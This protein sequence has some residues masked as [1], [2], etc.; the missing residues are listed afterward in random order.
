M[1]QHH[2]FLGYG[3]HHVHR[4]LHHLPVSCQPA[5]HRAEGT[6]FFTTD[7]V[8][9]DLIEADGSVS[10]YV[11]FPQ[12]HLPIY[13]LRQSGD[14]TSADATIIENSNTIL[15]YGISVNSD[16]EVPEPAS[17]SLLGA[18]VLALCRRRRRR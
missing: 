2:Q 10:D 9:F 4:R 14:Y 12:I 11:N 3:G 7:P 8:L 6:I 5:G 18:G 15:E 13:L 1:K 17:L 16:G